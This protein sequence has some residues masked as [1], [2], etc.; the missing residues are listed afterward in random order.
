MCIDVFILY[1]IFFTVQSLNCVQLFAIQWTSAHQASLS[2]TIYRNLLQ[3]MSVE[4]V[5]PSNRLILCRPLLLQPSIFP[6]I[7]VFFNES[8]L[9]IRWPQYWSFSFS[10]SPSKEHSDWFPLGWTGWSPCSPRDSQKSSPTSQFNSINSSVLSLLYGPTV[11][12]IH[13]Y[14]KNHSLA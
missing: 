9:F 13:E 10:I 6:S 14:W 7:R 12:S 2:S 1:S 11:T 5:M 3:L 8:A 4:S